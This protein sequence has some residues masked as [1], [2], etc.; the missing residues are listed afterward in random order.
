MV[1]C[2]C[3]IVC[4]T[5][6]NRGRAALSTPSTRDIYDNGF[7][8]YLCALFLLSW[9]G[10]GERLQLPPVPF[11]CSAEHCVVGFRPFNPSFGFRFFGFFAWGFTKS[12]RHYSN[13]LAPPLCSVTLT[14]DFSSRGAWNKRRAGRQPINVSAMVVSV[15]AKYMQAY[16][17]FGLKSML[18]KMYTVSARVCLL[19]IFLSLSY[20]YSKMLEYR[21][22]RTRQG[23]FC[24]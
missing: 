12:W 3:P 17:Q 7:A 16:R 9:R 2:V 18:T 15:V 5:P 4:I 13:G 8:P 1:P 14:L 23:L 21:S 22:S 11:I 10:G 24:P 6:A 20:S 19:T